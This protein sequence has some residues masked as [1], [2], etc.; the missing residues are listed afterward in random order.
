MNQRRHISTVDLMFPDFTWMTHDQQTLSKVKTSGIFA[1]QDQVKLKVQQPRSAYFHKKSDLETCYFCR[2]AWVHMK[3][4][5][6]PWVLSRSIQLIMELW[7]KNCSATAIFVGED[8]CERSPGY[9]FTVSARWMGECYRSRKSN[10]FHSKNMEKHVTPQLQSA[11]FLEKHSP[12]VHL[13]TKAITCTY[14]W[15]HYISSG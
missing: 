6:S 1:L 9:L 11:L 10:Y 15:F 5:G 13:I 4:N 12:G 8:V 7:R 2:W 14:V 3:R